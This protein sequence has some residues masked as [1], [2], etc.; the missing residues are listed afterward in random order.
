MAARMKMARPY[1]RPSS[2]Y[3]CMFM[4]VCVYV[5]SWGKAR[6]DIDLQNCSC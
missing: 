4:C 1:M 2:V 5:F 3:V 6:V